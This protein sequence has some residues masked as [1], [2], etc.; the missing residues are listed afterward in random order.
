VVGGGSY[1]IATTQLKQILR[2]AL[3]EDA[4][5]QLDK[6]VAHKHSEQRGRRRY[7]SDVESGELHEINPRM[8][9]HVPACFFNQNAKSVLN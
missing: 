9:R 8:K 4:A 3:L 2:T 7:E 1:D 6:V 5:L